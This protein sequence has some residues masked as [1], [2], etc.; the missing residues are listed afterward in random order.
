MLWD[1]GRNLQET[2]AG[3]W[4]KDGCYTHETH[5]SLLPRFKPKSREKLFIQMLGKSLQPREACEQGIERNKW[6]AGEWGP[7]Q[8]WT[9]V[10]V[11]LVPSPSDLEVKVWYVGWG[12][13]EV[14]SREVKGQKCKVQT[15]AP[16]PDTVFQSKLA[17]VWESHTL[18]LLLLLLVVL[19]WCYFRLTFPEYSLASCYFGCGCRQTKVFTSLGS[20]LQCWILGPAS[21]LQNQNSQFNK[22]PRWFM[23]KLCILRF[24]SF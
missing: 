11:K 7:L 13:Q 19:I 20:L 18:L 10:P 3:W 14:L 8:H 22:I 24:K 17:K 12:I 15:A 6:K 2:Q 1:T 4:G 23:C 5:E 9:R 16:H 21:D